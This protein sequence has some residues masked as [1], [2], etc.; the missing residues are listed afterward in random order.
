[1][2]IGVVLDPLFLIYYYNYFMAGGV[3]MYCSGRYLSAV[4]AGCPLNIPP[5][6]PKTSSKNQFDHW[7]KVAGSG[8]F[9]CG[10]IHSTAHH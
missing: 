4:G 9:W 7:H 10:I 3:P 2:W 5:N 6:H 8:G 1:M